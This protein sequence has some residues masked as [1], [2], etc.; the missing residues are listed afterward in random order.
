MTARLEITQEK[1]IQSLEVSGPRFL[2]ITA[3]FLHSKQLLVRGVTQEIERT[4]DFGIAKTI[5][6]FEDMNFFNGL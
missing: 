2:H 5:L 4:H 3:A 6:L 1:M